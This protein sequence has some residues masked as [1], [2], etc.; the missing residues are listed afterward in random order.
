MSYLL[1]SHVLIWS[2]TD[3]DKLSSNALRVLEDTSN[4]V[5]VSAVSFW[6]I[7]L[8]YSLGKL[9][10]DGVQPEGLLDL[11]SKTGFEPIPLLPEE[12]AIYHRMNANWHR[13]PFD[14]MLICQALQRNLTLVSKDKSISLYQ[15]TGLKV[16]W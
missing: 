8:K 1:D 10:L 7:S 6:E 3:P 2:I 4:T 11:A 12:A 13:D 9:D 16:L 15:D 14:R 5:Y